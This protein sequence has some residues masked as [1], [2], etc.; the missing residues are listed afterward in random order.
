MMVMKEFVTGYDFVI[1]WFRTCHL[2]SCQTR[3]VSGHPPKKIVW[4]VRNIQL[5]K[6][7]CPGAV[8]FLLR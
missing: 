1:F 8:L 2:I 5:W 6:V 7:A 3:E 4:I